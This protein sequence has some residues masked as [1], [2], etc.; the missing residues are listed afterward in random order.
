MQNKSNSYQGSLAD[1]YIGMTV[2]IYQPQEFLEVETLH[3]TEGN[4]AC[5][6]AKIVHRKQFGLK[7]GLCGRHF[8]H[9]PVSMGPGLQ[10]QSSQTVFMAFQHFLHVLVW[11]ESAYGKI[12]IERFERMH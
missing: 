2:S 5:E 9:S 1:L 8:F 6:E 3:H 11:D 12:V 7:H 10:K 4:G